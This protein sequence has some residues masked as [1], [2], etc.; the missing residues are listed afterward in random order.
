MPQ[1]KLVLAS[2]SYLRMLAG[3]PP[4]PNWTAGVGVYWPPST[5]RRRAELPG[6]QTT[7][8]TVEPHFPVCKAVSYKLHCHTAAVELTRRGEVG[9]HTGVVSHFSK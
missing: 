2:V 7:G 1:K 3:F 5:H 4:F 8:L 9:V 6:L